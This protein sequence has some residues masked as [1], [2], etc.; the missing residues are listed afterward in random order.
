MSTDKTT[1]AEEVSRVFERRYQA[2]V[3]AF[4]KTA[5]R[6]SKALIAQ[7]LGRSEAALESVFETLTKAGHVACKP[8]RY[9]QLVR[10]LPA[11]EAALAQHLEQISSAIEQLD[12]RNQAG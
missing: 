6:A 2:G 4:L 8:S 10:I 7:R 11:G 9:G 1:H 3:L 12:P 5:R